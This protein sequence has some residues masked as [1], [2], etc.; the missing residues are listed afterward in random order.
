MKLASRVCC[1]LIV[2]FSSMH[3]HR[4]ISGSACT[5]TAKISLNGRE[6]FEDIG[7]LDFEDTA[8]PYLGVIGDV[9]TAVSQ[10][11]GRQLPREY[12]CL[13]ARVSIVANGNA[14]RVFR[15][16]TPSFTMVV[17]MGDGQDS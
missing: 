5:L 3:E 12:A 15:A 14:V 4:L 6:V 9:A 17:T 13:L 11:R 10:Y 7:Q 16:S 8:V 2:E 1:S